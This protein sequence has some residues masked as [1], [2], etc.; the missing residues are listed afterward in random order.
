[1]AKL[2]YIAAHKVENVPDHILEE[3]QILARKMGDVLRPLVETSE[4]NI[5]LGALNWVHA[6][7][8]KRLVSDDPEEIDK[9]AKITAI[10]LMKNIEMLKNMKI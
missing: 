6:G 7:I 2:K 8:I 1:M 10:S 9:A 5:A 4:P 3:M